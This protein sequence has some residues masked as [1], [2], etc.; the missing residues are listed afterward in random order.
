MPKI[1]T[2]GLKPRR[3]APAGHDREEFSVDDLEVLFRH[4][5]QYRESEPAKC[6]VTVVP[7]FTGVRI[8]ELAQGAPRWRFSGP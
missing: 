2:V 1:V 3:A 6:W 7:A 8:E 4:A 5:A